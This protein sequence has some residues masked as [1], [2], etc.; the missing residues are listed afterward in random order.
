VIWLM[1]YLMLM[2]EVLSRTFLA[3]ILSFCYRETHVFVLVQQELKY[4]VFGVRVFLWDRP[5]V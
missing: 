5:R 2:A 3:R 1:P 4:L